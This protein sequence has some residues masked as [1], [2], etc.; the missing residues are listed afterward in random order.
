MIELYNQKAECTGCQSC[1]NACPVHA[2]TM[3][4]D[5][6]GFL[7]PV[8]D[9]NQCKECGLCEKICRKNPPIQTSSAPSAYA[10]YCKDDNIRQNS[11]SGGLFSV[12][13]NQILRRDGV[14]VGAAMKD[15]FKGVEHRLVE[16]EEGLKK[17]RGSKYVQSNIGDSYLQVK[18]QL[19]QGKTVYFSGTPCQ[20]D[21]LYRYLRKDYDHLY[22]QDLIC[23]GVPSPLAWC[24]YA[25]EQEKNRQ[26]TIREVSFRN[27]T[28]GWKKYAMQISF[29]NNEKY[30]EDLNTDSYLKGFM[31][32]NFLRPSCH[33]CRYKTIQRSADITLADL[34]GAQQICPEMDD[35]RGL[36]L[37]IVH[38]GKGMELLN[39]VQGEIELKSVDLNAA[40]QHNPAMIRSSTAGKNRAAFMGS[41]SNTTYQ[42][43]FKKYIEGSRWNQFASKVKRGIKKLLRLGKRLK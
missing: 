38:S 15:D 6:E 19:E 1:A 40:I 34:W 3:Q 13:A 4:T 25:Q 5:E 33:D 23:H 21:G 41:F 7:Y 32:D 2:I 9:R 22:T 30:C 8:I 24:K 42:K 29:A 27:K 35:D 26:S 43:L 18:K 20:I 12:F 14:V 37:V 36:S 11:S 39:A 28:L 10:A 31:S 17:L 16:T